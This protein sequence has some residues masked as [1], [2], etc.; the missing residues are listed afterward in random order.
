MSLPWSSRQ[1]TQVLV[2]PKQ[3]C[4]TPNDKPKRKYSMSQIVDASTRALQQQAT[5]TAKS[6]A[7]LA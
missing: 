1:D 6:M 7:Q 2:S 3:F 4:L 5:S